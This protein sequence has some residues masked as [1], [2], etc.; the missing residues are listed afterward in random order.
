M[1]PRT[2][3]YPSQRSHTARNLHMAS[4]AKSILERELSVK[5]CPQVTHFFVQTSVTVSIH[6][7]RMGCGVGGDS[8][9][10][11]RTGQSH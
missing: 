4:D 1:Y 3:K 9:F 7:L 11:M 6:G 8:S 2:S 10:E 5:T